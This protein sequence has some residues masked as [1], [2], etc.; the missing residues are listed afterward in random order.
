MKKYDKYKDSG[1]EW[2]G[3]IPIDWHVKKI[4]YYFN[5]ARGLSITKQNLKDEGIPCVNYGEIHSK[6]G[7]FV[8]PEIHP[9]KY[10]DEEYLQTSKKS[11]LKRGDFVFAD[12]SEDIEGSGNFT[13]LNSDVETFAG[14][15]TII[16]RQNDL[17]YK[18]LAFYFDSFEYRNQIRSA[19]YGIKV[20]SI[21]QAILKETAFIQPPTKKEQTAIANY[22]DKKNAQ[23]D[24]LIEDK[25][26]LVELYKEEKTAIIN[27]AVTKGINPDVKLKDSGIEW[28][29]EIPEHWET[30]RL[31]YI[32]KEFEAGVSVNSIDTAIKDG[33]YGILKT[34]CVYDYTFRPEQNKL[35]HNDEELAR[36]RVNPKEGQIIISRMN[37]PELVGASGF[38][39]KDYSELFLPDRLWQTVFYEDLEFDS[40]YVSYVLKSTN[41]RGIISVLA[42]GTSPSMKNISQSNYLNIEVPFPS[43]GI[44]NQIVKHIEKESKNIDSKISKVKKHIELLSEYRTSLISEVVTGKIKVID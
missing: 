39:S 35:I 24:Q 44:Q 38:V 28:L 20:F 13:C 3:E 4:G 27:Q 2:I 16:L 37:T 30:R 21:T 10:V 31:K 17:D 8:D 1:I 14:Y 18:F 19:V 5:F 25:K 33:E 22:L 42:S 9:L 11:L 36:A 23:I 12:T 40:K 15:H 43:Q 26:R 6:Y 41:F 29:G 7:V 34:S 32:I